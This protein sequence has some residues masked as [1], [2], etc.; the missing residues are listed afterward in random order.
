MQK[1]ATCSYYLIGYWYKCLELYVYCIGTT[2]APDLPYG[3]NLARPRRG[4]ATP[5][6]R[7]LDDP[8][9]A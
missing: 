8:V 5:A 1:C 6:A 7:E 4:D 2:A 9:S 3:D